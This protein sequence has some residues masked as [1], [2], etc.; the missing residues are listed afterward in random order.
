MET[1]YIDITSLT[2]LLPLYV[3]PHKS[4]TNHVIL[5]TLPGNTEPCFIYRLAI[6][7]IYASVN[8]TFIKV[9]NYIKR[10]I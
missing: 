6:N 4:Y 5:L 3:K 7:R 2:K 10:N 1:E 9:S 8:G